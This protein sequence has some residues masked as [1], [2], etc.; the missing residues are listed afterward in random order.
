MV[1]IAGS[2]RHSLAGYQ[3]LGESPRSC[4]RS[5]SPGN[6]GCLLVG[7]QNGAGVPS[8]PHRTW[9]QQLWQKHR[10]I[11]YRH[12]PSLGPWAAVRPRN[13]QY[14]RSTAGQ[15]R[16]VRQIGGGMRVFRRRG[17]SKKRLR[18][19]EGDEAVGVTMGLSHPAEDGKKRKAQLGCTSLE[20]FEPRILSLRVTRFTPKPLRLVA[21]W[22][23]KQRFKT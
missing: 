21:T 7:T 5:S 8:L 20:C 10:C 13:Q 17:K 4:S 6:T 22:Q 11:L 23:W 19:E 2:G 9:L 15:E 12:G 14:P 16:M 18:R 3:G 1:Y